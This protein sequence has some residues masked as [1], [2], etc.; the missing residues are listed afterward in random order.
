[1]RGRAIVRSGQ[2]EGVDA[3]RPVFGDGLGMAR[4]RKMDGAA[5]EFCPVG[6]SRGVGLDR[7]V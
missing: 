4:T 7:P 2:D 5:V 3:R 6:I 1:M